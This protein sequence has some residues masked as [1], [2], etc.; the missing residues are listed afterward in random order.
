MVKNI[1]DRYFMFE[2]ETPEEQALITVSRI[3]ESTGFQI[4]EYYRNG[5]DI[6]Y[7]LNGSGPH[8]LKPYGGLVLKKK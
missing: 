5:S 2:R 4:P 6:L 7:T 1:N 8:E 3:N